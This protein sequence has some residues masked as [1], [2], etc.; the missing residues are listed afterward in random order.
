MKKILKLAII[1]PLVLYACNPLDM[2]NPVPDPIEGWIYQLQTKLNN[3][4]GALLCTM[5]P[6]RTGQPLMGWSDVDFV[7]LFG[8][9]P[10]VVTVSAQQGATAT[11]WVESTMPYWTLDPVKEPET[12]PKV[13]SFSFPIP[14]GALHWVMST[15]ENKVTL[16][17]VHKL[18]GTDTALFSL[19]F[20]KPCF[21]G[22]VTINRFYSDF[23]G[24]FIFFV[25]VPGIYGHSPVYSGFR[26]HF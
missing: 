22:T 19:G 11:V 20:I 15:S 7:R 9:T 5:A 14:G 25:K 2:V 23:E 1:L 6:G 4:N 18:G 24:T 26:V 21:S 16:T 3:S 8:L 10:E 13:E 17:C 12:A